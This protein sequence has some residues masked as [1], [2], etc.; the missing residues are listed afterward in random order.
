[1]NEDQ[2]APTDDRGI[3]TAPDDPHPDHPAPTADPAPI[4]LLRLLAT[5]QGLAG[6]YLAIWLIL[7]WWT[8]TR[9]SSGLF[10]PA[11][12]FQLIPIII[13]YLFACMAMV[14]GWFVW[15]RHPAGLVLSRI[16]WAMQIPVI[17]VFTLTYQMLLGG[18]FYLFWSDGRFSSDSILGPQTVIGWDVEVP[19]SYFGV[20]F[21]ALGFFAIFQICRF[22]RADE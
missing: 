4:G 15:L 21:V 19:M 8:R 14:G 6:A 3:E 10:E 17:Q 9:G 2:P 7:S 5:L 22:E 16:V 18:G 11:D 1:M 12:S 13:S 20:N